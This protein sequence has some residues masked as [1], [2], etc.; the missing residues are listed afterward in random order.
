MLMLRFEDLP[1]AELGPTAVTIGVL[2]GVHRGHR[3]LIRTTIEAARTRDVTSAVLIFD[4]HPAAFF[5]PDHVPNA[6]CSVDYRRA[7]LETEEVDALVT[8]Q[9]D[10]HLA[11]LDPAAYIDEI[12]IA[13]LGAQVVCVGQDFTF[14]R[15]RAGTS[16]VLARIG[17]ERGLE[18][19][20]VESVRLG[21]RPVSSTRVR[22][23]LARGHVTEAATLLGR[24]HVVGGRIVRGRRQAGL[25]GFPT[26]NLRLER[27]MLPAAGI[28]SGLVRLDGEIYPGA[29][30]IRDRE[31]HPDGLVRVEAHLDGL[32]GQHYGALASLAFLHYLRRDLVFEDAAEL[33]A[34]I[35]LDCKRAWR[36]TQRFSEDDGELP[37]VWGA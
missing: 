6:L 10:E 17:P 28:Y 20:V 15:E 12:L 18:V 36:D 22:A 14:G 5:D 21:S 29:I 7:L 31:R 35:D 24:R 1:R 26:I 23:A 2:D 3:R 37:V 4:P 16:E 27:G 13:R 19:V 30:Y 33:R 25:T 8:L 32:S 9:F 34:R 11:S